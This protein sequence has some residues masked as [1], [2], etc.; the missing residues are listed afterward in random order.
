MVFGN[1][2]G[3]GEG[4]MLGLNRGTSINEMLK[5]KVGKRSQLWKEFC[6]PIT[7]SCVRSWCRDVPSAKSF[8]QTHD[9]RGSL[10]IW[11]LE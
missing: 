2:K 8:I 10:E 3:E 9:F 5:N 7:I 4:T 6:V 1:G 11:M